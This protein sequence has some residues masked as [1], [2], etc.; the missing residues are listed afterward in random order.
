MTTMID[1]RGWAARFRS[2][3]THIGHTTPL[4]FWV[5]DGPRP[6]GY[7]LSET[8]GRPVSAESFSNFD[9]YEP[10]VDLDATIVPAEPGWWVVERDG[11]GAD[12]GWWSKVLAWRIT[13][14]GYGVKAIGTPFPDGE[15]TLVEVSEDKVQLVFD[16]ERAPCADG[17]WPTPADEVA[18]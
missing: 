14:D 12:R 9:C 11:N 1:A 7:T 3:G 10:D 2:V 15:A 18:A 13:N 8:T 5:F 16:P 4:L 6:V 17:P